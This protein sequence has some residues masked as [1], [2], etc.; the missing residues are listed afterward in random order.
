MPESPS[1]LALSPEYIYE[2]RGLGDVFP[3]NRHF[4]VVWMGERALGAAFQMEGAFNEEDVHWFRPR[5]WVNQAFTL[6]ANLLWNHGPYV[7]DTINGYR[8]ITRRAFD[9][10][11]P[12]ADGFVL[13]IV[14]ILER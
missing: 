3:D 1:G 11:K 8:G 5:K 10:L 9:L 12:E 13:R 2:I 4:G 14:I 6:A 7:T